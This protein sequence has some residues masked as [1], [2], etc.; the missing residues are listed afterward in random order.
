MSCDW[1]RA[2]HVTALPA[3]IGPRQ[4]GERGGQDGGGQVHHGLHLPDLWCRGPRQPRQERGQVFQPAARG[5]RERQN[6]PQQQFVT[7]RKFVDFG[8]PST[9][10]EKDDRFIN[11]FH[12]THSFLTL[13][14]ENDQIDFFIELYLCS[15]HLI[16]VSGQVRGDPV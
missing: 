13:C 1:P 3:L 15:L 4:R 16:S 6:Y 10:L 5:L 7:L 14:K 2:G 11:N 9:F 12:F 8:Y